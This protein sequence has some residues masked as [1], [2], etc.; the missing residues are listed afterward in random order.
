[1]STTIEDGNKE[2]RHKCC[3]FCGFEEHLLSEA[4]CPAM[5]VVGDRSDRIENVYFLEKYGSVEAAQ[6]HFGLRD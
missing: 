2:T 3:C 5:A 1:M 4:Q 6:K